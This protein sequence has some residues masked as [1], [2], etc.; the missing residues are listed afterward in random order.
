VLACGGIAIIDDSAGA[1]G[2]PGAGGSAN[3]STTLASSSSGTGAQ[4]PFPCDAPSGPGLGFGYM[5][6]TDATPPCLPAGSPEVDEQFLDSL[7]SRCQDDFAQC[8][9]VE[10]TAVCGPD[11]DNA[12]S[13]CYMVLT[14]TPV[15]GCL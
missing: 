13:C 9:P 8:C 11:P 1:A 15:M 7:L 3:S 5:C 4:A 10:A 12:A 2:A 14:K 6:L